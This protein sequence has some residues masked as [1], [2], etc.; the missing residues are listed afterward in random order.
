MNYRFRNEEDEGVDLMIENL[1]HE[2]WKQIN[3]STYSVSDMGRFKR[4]GETKEWLIKPYIKKS[5]SN[6][7]LMIKIDGKALN[8]ARL[9]ATAF[10]PNPKNKEF[11][12]RVSAPHNIKA[13]ALEWRTL[14]ELGEK[15]GALARKKIVGI[16]GKRG[17]TFKEHK[18]IYVLKDNQIIDFGNSSRKLAKRYF[19]SHQTI[20]DSCNERYKTNCTGFKFMWANDVIDKNGKYIYEWK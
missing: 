17:R 19:C 20:L 2:T 7:P 11:V 1:K 16:N 3:N 14:K 18:E 12:M 6:K 13:S 15:T 9:V 5:S 10:V 4:I 8:A